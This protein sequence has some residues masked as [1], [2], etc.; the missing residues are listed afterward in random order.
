MP[1]DLYPE[2]V[3]NTF[4]GIQELFLKR[5]EEIEGT[6]VGLHRP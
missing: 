2:M 5:E 6:A 4:P 3:A 1:E